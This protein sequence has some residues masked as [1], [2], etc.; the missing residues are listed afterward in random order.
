MF[1]GTVA[2]FRVWFIH[3]IHS[4]KLVQG[5]GEETEK[6]CRKT[7]MNKAA[8]YTS[9]PTVTEVD[10]VCIITYPVITDFIFVITGWVIVPC[11]SPQALEVSGCSGFLRLNHLLRFFCYNAF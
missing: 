4:T 11:P 9:Q 7:V 3:T 2:L 8:N 10:G 5:N 1:Y 6:E